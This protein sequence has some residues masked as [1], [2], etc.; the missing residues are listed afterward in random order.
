MTNG[1]LM[2]IESIAEYFWP[3]FSD[4]WS[5]KPICGL[6]ESGHFTQVLLYTSPFYGRIHKS[7]NLQPLPGNLQLKNGLLQ[8]TV[9]PHKSRKNGLPQR[10]TGLTQSLT[11][12]PQS[13]NG[14]L[15]SLNGLPQSLIGN[16]RILTSRLP[17]L[18]GCHLKKKDQWGSCLRWDLPIASWI[19]NC[20]ESTMMM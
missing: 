16:L 17:Q 4:N 6:F 15:Q 2:Q 3:A 10:K 12:V 8:K 20:W 9:T 1:S 18:I 13:L 5:W 14:L 11:G 7:S 19:T